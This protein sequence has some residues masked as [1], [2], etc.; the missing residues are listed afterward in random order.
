MYIYKLQ[1]LLDMCSK[2]FY[3]EMAGNAFF[4]EH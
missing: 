2:Y 1:I 4:K 3:D